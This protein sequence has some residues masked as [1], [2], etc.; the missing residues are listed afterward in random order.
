MTDAAGFRDSSRYAVVG[1]SHATADA[2]F[3][4]RLFVDDEARLGLLAK[5]RDHDIAQAVILSTCDRVEF[6]LALPDPER[7]VRAI[8]DVVAER[9]GNRRTAVEEQVF[10][11]YDQDAVRHVFRVACALESQV[12]GES[13]VLGQVKHAFSQS[14]DADMVGTDLDGLYQATFSLAKQVRTETRIGEGA[15]TVASAAA[16]IARDLHG[17]PAKI[18]LLVIGLGDTGALLLE[19]FRLA[20][21]QECVLTGPSRRTERAALRAQCHF[22][23]FDTLP[24]AL[25]EADAV[26]TASGTGRFLVDRAAAS[27]ALRRRRGMP[28]IFF[29]CGS[30]EDV[31]PAVDDLDGAFRYTLADLE[32]M[33]RE[34]KFGRHEQALQ[35]A[36]MVDERVVS[37]Q[38]SLAA[39]E[40]IPG[41]V[42]LRQHFEDIRRHVIEQHASADAEEATRLLINHLLHSPSKVLREVA[43]Q[44]G[45]ADLRDTITVNRVVARLFDLR[46]DEPGGGTSC[47]EQP[48]TSRNDDGSVE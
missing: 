14:R 16:Q 35:A 1:A 2:A 20:G 4:D 31:D 15:V 24:D 22:A 9:T 26:I 5:L 17:D 32:R 34:G 42:A 44:G 38:K 11:R 12:V 19:Q 47:G 25:V 28:V 48:A 41:L 13:Q 30:P 45:V 18:R 8:E 23:P 7:G 10:R 36:R 6:H 27:G 29:D 37:F 43:A 21:V 39:Q 46:L 33:A 40:G 3:R